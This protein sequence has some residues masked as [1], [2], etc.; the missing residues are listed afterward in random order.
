MKTIALVFSF[1]VF[2]NIVFSQTKE[3]VHWLN[4]EQVE[5][6]LRIAPKKVFIDFYADWC[7]PCIRMEKEI[8]TDRKIIK[9]INRE[10][11]AVKMNIESNDTIVFGNQ[12]FVNERQHR[13]NP[14][15][16]IPLLMASRKNK[17]FSLPAFVFM[18]KNFEAKARYFQYL[19]V[20][21]L[22]EILAN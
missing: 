1:F 18:D 15:H 7:V 14:I 16:Q 3:T 6:S 10:Y 4:F 21:Q 2:G 17:P 8:F 9:L 19:N 11:Y 22:S 13:K 5:D 12:K 20:D